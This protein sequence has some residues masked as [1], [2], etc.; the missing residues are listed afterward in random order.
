[1][2]A[3]YKFIYK[4]KAIDRVFD[5]T[6]INNNV[7]TKD[8]EKGTSARIY[9]GILTK[10]NSG[11]N[12][13]EKTTSWKIE[14]NKDNHPMENVILTDTF[15]N[16]G[17][18]L[19]PDTLVI[20]NASGGTLT[21]G[22]DYTL[23]DVNDQ[24]FKITF[25]KPITEKHTL[26][27]DTYFD[28]EAREKLPGDPNPNDFENGVE[29]TW[30]DEFGEDQSKEANANFNP[31]QWTKDNGFKY[32]S[33]N[34]VEKEI[35]WQIGVNYNLNEVSEAYVEDYILGDQELVE[36]SIQVYK[37]VISPDG[38]NY[39]WGDLVPA[40]DYDLNLSLTNAEGN[41]GF[42]ID[43]GTI[44]E[45]YVIVYKTSL[46]DKIIVNY[47]ENKAYYY[48]DSTQPIEL[49][50]G[51]SV[52][53]GTEYTTKSGA[54][55]G[56]VMNWNV[57]I[58]FGQSQVANAKVID[59]PSMNQILLE[60]T[61]HL[62][63]TT[64]DAAGN[65]S[66]KTD[67]TGNFVE[68]QRGTDYTL[69]I[70]TDETG[71]QTFELAFTNE[72]DTAYILEYQSYINALDREDVSNTVRFE[73]VNIQTDKT[74]TEASEQVKFTAGEGSGSG[75]RGRLVV[76]KVDDATGETLAGATFTLYDKTGEIAI[77]TLTTGA[78][79][80]V[81]F[82][83][84]LYG[85]YILQE[86]DAPEGY[87]VGINGQQTVT[88]N[89]DPTNVTIRNKKIIRAVELVK[90]DNQTG[91]KLV[92][93]TFSLQQK[94]GEQYEE[95]AQLTTDENG[96]IFKDQLQPGDYQFVEITAPFGYVLDNTPIP[97]TIGEN[98]TEIIQLTKE[99]QIVLGAVE[100]WKV[101]EDD[102]NTGLVG[103]E[104]K[105]LKEDGSVIEEGLTTNDEG[106]IVVENLRPGTYQ[107][108]ETNAPEFYQ[109]NPE[110]YVFTIDLNQT[111]IATVKAVNE[112]TPGSVELTKVDK[113]NPD[114]TLEGAV[115]A[116]QDSEGNTLQEDLETNAEGKLV[117]NN[118]KPGDYQLVETA[119]PEYY[120][121]DSTPIEF[122]IEKGQTVIKAVTAE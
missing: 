90:E 33:Y 41:P 32:G 45:P 19:I 87:V 26:T 96:A 120:Q 53:H 117:I 44:H 51:V 99:N 76:T 114:L 2:N 79:G 75:E 36:E 115:F 3:A 94:N 104:F 57:H 88:V 61:F 106:K 70:S 38:K 58:N 7:K 95:I 108:V 113:D 54:Q 23:S 122:T 59:E 37:M 1:I 71:K 97:F 11:A 83:N 24:G 78:D 27:Y 86:D 101:G 118:L 62:Y 31:N 4:T 119:A 56:L 121:L 35:T 82:A 14:I 89:N 30:V 18:T 107:L 63:E 48:E 10:G 34:A 69:E 72:I 13:A 16:K 5:D 47:Y 9:Q 22:E 17:L 8:Y 28:Y 91:A 67:E 98:Q 116:L 93:A 50:A 84:L 109:L 68:L 105:L 64:V 40:T 66:K 73:G 15:K 25:L 49:G 77:R 80:K 81:T 21:I 65:V 46:K 52:K 29:V 6:T 12:Y 43:L 102:Q 103:A 110:P 112:L 85:D 74:E 20:K 111:E 55:A 39:T 100:L 92:G 42:K 60:N